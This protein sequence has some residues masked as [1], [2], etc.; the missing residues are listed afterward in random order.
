MSNSEDK[1]AIARL[2]MQVNELTKDFNTVMSQQKEVLDLVRNFSIAIK[3]GKG[4]II[5]GILII[6]ALGHSG[7]E[8]C[9]SLIKA[10]IGN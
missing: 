3:T 2:Q 5:L 7:Y 8:W 4:M 9:A 10:L 1:V 6:G